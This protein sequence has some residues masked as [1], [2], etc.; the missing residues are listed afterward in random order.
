M[1]LNTPIV[2]VS[3]PVLLVGGGKHRKR[4][5]AACAGRYGALV[6]ADSGADWLLGQGL[7]PDKVIGDL[8]SVSPEALTT[9]G[10]ERVVRVK[11]QSSTDF[12]K[13]LT[14]IEAPLVLGVGFLGGR[15]DHELAAL[16]TL[17]SYPERRCVLIGGQD[18][19]FLAPPK[20]ALDLAAGTRV[21]L[22]PFGA[23][24]ARATGL[25]W[26]LEGLRFD[27]ARLIG[28]SNTALGP[29][30]LEVDAPDM[31]VI[32]PR[33]LLPRCLA[34]LAGDGVGWPARSPR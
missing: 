23:V 2:H 15:L 25:Q 33:S 11:E 1:P 21:S 7:M 4:G 30:Q 34:A 3:D 32:L 9:L 28:T 26:P 18:I 20:L 24:T 29:V 16:H 17:V 22:F 14:R 27:P 5:L 8:D 6:A 31:L 12:E 19:V 10:L 13:C